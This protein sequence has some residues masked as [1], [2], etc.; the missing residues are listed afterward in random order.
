MTSLSAR[1]TSTGSAAAGAASD[2][3]TDAQFLR[4]R[5]WVYRRTG[6]RFADSKRYFVDKR[7]L[8]CVRDHGGDFNA[9]FASLRTGADERAAQ[10]LVNELTVNETY[11]LREDH[12][13]DSLVKHVLPQV[14]AERRAT[15]DT[16][17]VRI[18][19]LPCSTGEE[20]YSIALRLLTDWADIAEMDVEIVAGDIDTRVLDQARRGEYGQRSVQKVPPAVLRE[21]FERI[22]DRYRVAEDIRGA[23]DFTLMNITDTEAMRSFRDFDVAFCRNLLIYF[24]EVS[25]RRAA[26]HLFGAL[27]PGG[28]LFLG[29]SESMSR[30]SPIFDAVRL[31]DGI[32]YQRPATRMTSRY[33]R[34]SNGARP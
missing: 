34:P 20:P 24:D 11:F 32:A 17:P 27:R 33:S 19:S 26:E 31:P 25:A 3:L 2:Q 5:E 12:Q 13:F 18:L 10:A 14:A 7:V 6:M 4:V 30:I 1:P 21:H 9:W 16:S 22:G 15:G 29:H 8:S 28:L 23:I